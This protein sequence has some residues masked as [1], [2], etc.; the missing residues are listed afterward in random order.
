MG[1]WPLLL[2]A[3]SA[4]LVMLVLTSTTPERASAQPAPPATFAGQIRGLTP[5]DG[6]SV[7]AEMNGLVCGLSTTFVIDGV[8]RY[9]VHVNGRGSPDHL[10]CGVTGD[11]V[12]FYVDG[13]YAGSWTWDAGLTVLDLDVVN[14]P[15]GGTGPSATPG[16]PAATPFP[17]QSGG[18]SPSSC[19]IVGYPE[20]EFEGCGRVGVTYPETIDAGRT[21]KFTLK[22][23]LEDPEVFVFFAKNLRTEV[24]CGPLPDERTC[25]L[26]IPLYGSMKARISSDPPGLFPDVV[27][28]PR[29]AERAP[30]SW[31]WEWSA[32]PSSG[33]VDYRV[34]I[35]LETGEAT[36]QTLTRFPDLLVSVPAPPTPTRTPATPT[37]TPAA[38]AT[39]GAMPTATATFTPGGR[40]R[41][42]D[43]RSS[44]WIL[45]TVTGLAGLGGLVPLVLLVIV[46]RSRRG[47]SPDVFLSYRRGDAAGWTGRIFDHLV[48]DLGDEHVFQDI[49]DIEGG[50]D[51][52]DE[53]HEKV[54][55]CDVLIA[56]IGERW[57]G[58]QPDGGR[59]IDQADDWVRLETARALAGT[60]VVI[61]VLVD[62]MKMSALGELPED[63]SRLRRR[64]AIEV[65]AV[66]FDADMKRLIRAVRSSRSRR[67]NAATMPDP[68]S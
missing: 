62:G 39:S 14:P 2:T 7:R 64:N 58:S 42:G 28:A 35:T 27:A 40:D 20:R 23:A 24:P 61:P 65:S 41:G 4:V 17:P 26:S 45:L 30:R 67:K 38:T 9:R 11:R 48:K 12:Y 29:T 36:P 21:A 54:A 66:N 6:L 1:W 25:S 44:V 31:L 8:M 18:G 52:V 16:A 68:T 34:T 53:L 46:P 56:L 3:A 59:R 60:C 10:H 49:V 33:P 32:S 51:W 43:G 57:V 5:R 22:A 47:N 19:G 15:Q 50:V 63:L 13:V 55:T 37:S